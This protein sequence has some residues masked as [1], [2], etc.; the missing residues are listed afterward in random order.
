MEN[1]T[2]EDKRI[3]IIED[4]ADLRMNLRTY[5]KMKGYIVDDT[6]SPLEALEKIIKG[7]YAVVISDNRMP[8]ITGI[9]LIPAIKKSGAKLIL[10]SGYFSPEQVIQAKKEGADRILVK[11]IPL[12]ELDSSLFNL[13]YADDPMLNDDKTDPAA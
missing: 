2:P 4:E 3:L 5:L 8:G 1:N 6:N 11:P 13:F 12:H 10:M 9:S 7:K